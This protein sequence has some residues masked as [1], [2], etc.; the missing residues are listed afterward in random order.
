VGERNLE[1]LPRDRYG[2]QSVLVGFTSFPEL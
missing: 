2:H 1:Q